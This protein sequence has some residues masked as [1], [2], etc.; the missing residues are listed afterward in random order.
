M[1]SALHG[2]WCQVADMDRAT[3]FYRDVLGLEPS[4]ASKDWTEF[5][6]GADRIA[7]H[8][9]LRGFAPPHGEYGK[10]WFVGLRTDDLRALRARLEQA[11]VT[12]HGDYHDIPGGVILDFSDPDG[13]TLEAIQ[14]G[15]A[16]AELKG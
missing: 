14:L 4:Y 16:A 6:L 5:N 1:I 12:I 10:G 13:N 11:G 8:S 15:V 2:V 7:L 9:T 3:A